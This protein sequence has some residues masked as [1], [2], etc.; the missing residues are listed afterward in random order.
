MSA[1][2]FKTLR[3]QHFRNYANLLANFG[4]GIHC[5]TGDNGQG[6]TNLMEALH[7]LALTRGWQAKTEKFALQE[8]ETF[9][10]CE[11]ELAE[12]D[13]TP[14][15]ACNYLEGKGKKML[16]NGQPVERVADH[17]GRIPVLSVLPNDTQL[18]H[19]SPGGRRRFMDSFLSQCNPAYLQQLIQYERVV[20]QRNA[21]LGQMLEQRRWDADMVELWDAQL[22]PA[23]QFLAQ[24]RQEFLAEYLPLFTRHFHLIVSERETPDLQLVTQ[25]ADNS[26]EGWRQLLTQHRDR[27]R[28]S[29]RTQAG[30]HKDD[31][32]FTISGQAVRN[33][34]SQG[35]QKTYVI[36]LKLA[37][38]DLLLARTG[39]APLLLLDD[40]F[41]KLD[42]HRLAALARILDSEV[43]GQVFITDTSQDRMRDI[44]APLSHR[45][46]RH[47]RVQAGQLLAS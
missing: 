1:P 45:E 12:G 35:Q 33:Y 22:I 37:Q 8:G 20:D 18:I 47:Y 30:V 38:Y 5:I 43:T 19:G 13:R 28:Y 29:G 34:G 4:P 11:G 14:V 46:V 40:I 27:D 36:A 42:A 3:L 26:T 15:I 41:D 31:L 23:G 21:L 6:K 24:A 7:Y 44:F 10:L 39:K 16:V 9:F 2:W 32:E 25:V 17:V